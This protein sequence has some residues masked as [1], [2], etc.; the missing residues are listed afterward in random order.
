V[1]L[2]EFPHKTV[3]QGVDPKFKPQYHKKRKKILKKKRQDATISCPK[4][5]HYKFK[6]T[7]RL[8]VRIWDKKA[9]FHDS[10]S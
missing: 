2:L 4:E 1:S 6:N 3:A 10:L 9:C 5:T 7:N 8:I